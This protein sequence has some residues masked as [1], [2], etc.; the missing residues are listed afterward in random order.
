MK[1]NTLL[2][3][4]MRNL[5]ILLLLSL[6]FGTVTD[7]DGNTYNTVQIG[8]QM[9]MA[10]NLK[11]TH[12]N[13]GT[14][15]PNLVDGDS[16]RFTSSGAYCEYDNMDYD[17]SLCP[18]EC[19]WMRISAEEYVAI[20]GRLYNGYAISDDRG[21]C[22]EDWHV[23]NEDDWNLLI[24]YLGDNAG[25]ELKTTYG[26]YDY[27]GNPTNYGTNESGFSGLPGGK[28]NNFGD[29]YGVGLPISGY[30]WLPIKAI[31]W[32]SSENCNNGSCDA[33]NLF[34]NNN[35][36][37][38]EYAHPNYGLSIRCVQDQMQ[39]GCTDPEACNYDESAEVDDGSCE[40]EED[41][42][43]ECGGDLEW[44]CAGIC[45]GDNSSYDGCCGLPPN[46]DCTDDCV[47]DDLGQC[48][49]PQDVDGCGICFGDGTDCECSGDLEVDCCGVCG[50]DNSSCSNCCGMPFPDDCSE[51]CYEDN[52]GTC[53]ADSS[54]DCVQDCAG[55]WGGDLEIDECD[56]CGGDNTS[57]QQLGDLNG[58]GTINVIDIVMAVDLILNDNY[59]LVGDVNEDGQ[60]NVIDIVILVDWV[61]NG[62]PEA[63][64]DGDGVLDE[65]DS[66]PNNPYQCSDL[67]G[68]TCDDCSTGTF[69]PSD[70]GYDY[71]GDGQCDDGDCDDDNDGCQECWDSCP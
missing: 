29:P 10:E 50:G 60:L 33:K 61:L 39:G 43:G 17:F 24:D 4:D 32:V 37:G 36:V 30:D 54:N 38:T 7:I 8:T 34:V 40:Y 69:N 48:C 53:D 55:V 21:V 18:D 57:C 25:H 59:D 45:G 49:T 65:D 62:M 20:Y 12:Y 31:F 15:I 1:F 13:D 5:T 22:P 23:P 2:G 63:D 14:S 16:W 46:D 27:N 68:D 64:S 71:D 70:D 26:W 56:V 58:D 41:C 67:D 51:T 19:Y 6:S 42:A 47:I 52:C 11:V 9:W 66:D 28:R 3:G 44:D 35:Y